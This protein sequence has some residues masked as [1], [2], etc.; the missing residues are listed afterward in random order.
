M[1]RPSLLILPVP[2]LR[3]VVP[4]AAGLALLAAVVPAGQASAAPAGCTTSG[5]QVTC[6]FTETG[7]AQTWTVPSGITQATFTLYGAE[8]GNDTGSDAAGG[9]GAK[10]TGTLPVT[11]GTVLQVNAGQTGPPGGLGGT[12]AFGG[13]GLGGND[14]G[15]GGG[16]SDLRSPT[17][18]GSYPLANRLLVAGGGGGGG[19]NWFS[20]DGSSVPGGPGGSSGAPGT[21]GTDS[22][23]CGATLGGG[24]G[25]GPGTS[26]A[27]GTGGGGGPVSGTSS[28]LGVPGEGGGTG[29]VGT[30]GDGGLGDGGGGAGGGYFGGGGG[31]GAS[32][33]NT[34]GGGGGGGGG[35]SSYTGGASSATVTDGVAAPDDAPN[36]EV[37]ISYSLPVTTT[38]TALSSSANPSVAGQQV[39]YTATVSPVPDGGTVAFTDGGATITGCGAVTVSTT[40]GEATCQVTY[41]SAGARSI[42]AAYSGDAAFGAST[43]AAL[44]QTVNQAP[45]AT[46]V[47]SS[48][49]PSVS[50]QAVTFTATV[51]REAPGAGTPTGTVIFSADGSPIGTAPLDATGTATISTSSLTVGNHDI[52]ANYSGDGNFGTS[53]G[54][55]TQTVNQA[56][57]TTALA[58]SAN[59][60]APGQDV[61]FTAT[62]TADPPG[63][64]TPTGL[65]TFIADGSAIGTVPLDATG[66][67]AIHTSS[68]AAG[69]HS[70][71]ATYGGDGNFTASSAT[72]TQTVSKIATSTALASSAN[73]SIIGG[74]VTYTA[75]VSPAPDGGTVAFT[76]GGTTITG[77]GAVTVSS[78]GRATCQVT[79][80]AVGTHPITAAYTGDATYAAST[81]AA[82]TQQVA[83]AVKLLY[84]PAKANKSGATIPVKLQLLNATGTNVSAPGTVITVTGLS[85]SPAP[86]KAPTGTFTFM[87]F[88]QGPGYQLNVKTKGYPAGT[89]TLSFTAGSDPTTHTVQFVV[90]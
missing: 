74:Q 61:T 79:Y 6:I 11:A 77:C 52:T 68:L 87:T 36:G 8:G 50:G 49:N 41:T 43:S 59:P 73:P 60:S 5:N 62:V 64:G 12:R 18:D 56:A 9:L 24:A 3:R 10:V 28:C 46:R 38:V 35:G 7:S 37:I 30:G 21:P 63:A 71:I 13:G 84:N 34:N 86:G 14:G 40:T 44:T 1:R 2:R 66:T 75:T 53:S 4:V 20:Q 80:T 90:S 19:L 82:L 42:T 15:G 69:D 57:T 70:I 88:S 23:G 31:G 85:P 29:S 65:V 48:A 81:S 33:N 58:S 55:L 26:S 17:S 72:L 22:S 45:T 89:Y 25:G 27:G 16:A 39:T 76:D 47:A 32:D 83:Y 78:T 67:A 51:T 54:S